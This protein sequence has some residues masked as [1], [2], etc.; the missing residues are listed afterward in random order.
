MD[1]HAQIVDLRCS[2]TH[3]EILTNQAVLRKA[4]VR[5]GV[6]DASNNGLEHLE[7]CNRPVAL[8]GPPNWRTL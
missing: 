8:S 3:L 5:K 7:K 6:F 4:K 1:V 2:N